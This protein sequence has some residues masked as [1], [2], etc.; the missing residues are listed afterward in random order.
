MPLLLRVDLKTLSIILSL[1]IGAPPKISTFLDTSKTL[2]LFK[3]FELNSNDFEFHSCNL[4]HTIF[5]GTSA[6]LRVREN[7][8]HAQILAHSFLFSP[9]LSLLFCFWKSFEERGRREPCSPAGLLGPAN[10]NRPKAQPRR[11]LTP[12]LPS[13]PASAAYTRIEQGDELP[14]PDPL[15]AAPLG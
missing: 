13:F 11:Y 9:F 6:F 12:P 5:L 3:P 8:P 10:L 7:Y 4:V 14:A 15:T 1:F 2:S